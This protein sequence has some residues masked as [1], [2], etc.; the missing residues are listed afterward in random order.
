MFSILLADSAQKPAGTPNM[1]EITGCDQLASRD[2]VP[3]EESSETTL[4]SPILSM[5]KADVFVCVHT[6][7]K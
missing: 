7:S 2:I 1:P 5:H 4:L 3:E 6:G